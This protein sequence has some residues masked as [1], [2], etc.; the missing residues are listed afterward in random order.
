QD[1]ARVKLVFSEDG[2]ASF[3][4]PVIISEQDPAGRVDLVFT[5]T[6]KVLVTWLENMT[7]NGAIIRGRL[8]AKTGWCSEPFDIVTTSPA[9]KSGFPRLARSAGRIFLSWTAIE[10]EEV[11]RI[12]TGEL[13]FR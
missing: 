4:K 1:S 9:R 10:S 5:D 8:V 3:G 12:R 6:D 7:D 13:W 2:G 11:S